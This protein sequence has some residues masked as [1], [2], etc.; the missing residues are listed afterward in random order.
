MA[1]MLVNLMKLPAK[2]ELIKELKK[3]GIQIRRPLPPDK[4][5][6]E[7]NL[8][9]LKPVINKT[10]CDICILTELYDAKAIL[11]VISK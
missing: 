10:K 3:Q 6:I 5:R 2:D 9:Q 1:D 7:R 11:E 8:S 4:I